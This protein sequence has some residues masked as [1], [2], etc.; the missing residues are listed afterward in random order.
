[1][2]SRILCCGC[3]LLFFRA[4]HI[5]LPRVFLLAMLRHVLITTCIAKLL[6]P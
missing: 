2:S 4:F 5:L 1:M 6:R 3:W